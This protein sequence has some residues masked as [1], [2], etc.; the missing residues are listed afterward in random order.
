MSRVLKWVLAANVLVA[1]A[2]VFLYPHL[3]ISPAS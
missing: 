3:M 2:L 1:V